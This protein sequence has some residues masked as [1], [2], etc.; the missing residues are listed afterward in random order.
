M[1]EKKNHII[2][3][4]REVKQKGELEPNNESKNSNK[5]KG[6]RK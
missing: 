3:T 1:Y 5:K 4:G 2:K 6:K